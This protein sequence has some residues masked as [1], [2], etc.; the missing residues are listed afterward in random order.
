MKR[1]EHWVEWLVRRLRLRS[2]PAEVSAEQLMDAAAECGAPRH[3]TSLGRLRPFLEDQGIA[4]SGGPEK[5][6][7]LVGRAR[8]GRRGGMGGQR[9]C[10][11]CAASGAP[12]P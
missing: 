5:V 11:R 2:A 7:L 9:R 12:A 6:R 1:R 8:G 3:L 4:V 10:W